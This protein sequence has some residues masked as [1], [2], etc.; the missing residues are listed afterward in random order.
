[1]LRD[2]TH[3][4]HERS[5]SGRGEALQRSIFATTINSQSQCFALCVDWGIG[6]SMFGGYRWGWAKHWGCHL[7]LILGFFRPNASPL[8]LV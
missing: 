3:Q 2:E 6:R 7:Q 5:I 8:R 1:M 4:G